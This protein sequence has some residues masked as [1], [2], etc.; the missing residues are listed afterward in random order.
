[1]NGRFWPVAE[2]KIKQFRGDRK[3][4]VIKRPQSGRLSCLNTSDLDVPVEVK[5]VVAAGGIWGC[6][7][8]Q[9]M[10]LVRKR[11]LGRFF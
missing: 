2:V 5:A 10:T 1:V 11:P 4:A 7:T 3:T 8:D 6:R 9:R